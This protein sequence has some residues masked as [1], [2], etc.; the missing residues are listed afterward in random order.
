MASVGE[1]RHARRMLPEKMERGTVL[2]LSFHPFFVA[3]PVFVFVNV[4]WLC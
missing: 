3:W 4:Q 1:P 2:L